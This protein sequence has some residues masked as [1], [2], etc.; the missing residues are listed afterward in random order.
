MTSTQSTEIQTTDTIDLLDAF[1]A[2][3]TRLV[4]NSTVDISDAR[5]AAFA[6]EAMRFS[7]LPVTAK[8]ELIVPTESDAD[9]IRLQIKQFAREHNY[10]AGFPVESK[11]GRRLNE[12]TTV[13]FRLAPRRADDSTEDDQDAEI[14]SAD[15]AETV[16]KAALSVAK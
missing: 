12:G 6:Q 13:T 5:R 3:S 16:A 4:D 14:A 1:G 7:N 9:L 15:D 11:D 8:R 2:T 10:I